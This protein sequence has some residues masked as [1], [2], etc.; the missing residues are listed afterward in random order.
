[1]NEKK[2]KKKKKKK[3]NML[4]IRVG[5]IVNRYSDQITYS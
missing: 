1:M 3:K 2:K 5:G 4:I